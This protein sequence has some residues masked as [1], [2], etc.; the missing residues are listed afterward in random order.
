MQDTTLADYRYRFTRARRRLVRE[1]VIELVSEID[2][3]LAELPTKHERDS[4]PLADDGDWQ[5]LAG[6]V[7][8]IERLLAQDLARKGR[9][10]DLHRH[11]SF[12][13][14]VDL[15]D[16]AEWDWPS[17]RGDIMDAL[18]GELEPLPIDATDLGALV[19]ARPAG[20]VTTALHWAALDDD[21][22]ERL[23]FNLISQTAG[24]EN[25]RWLMK[26]RAPDRGR[27]LSVDRVVS[28]ALSGTRRERVIIQCKHWLSRSIPMPECA[29]AVAAVKLWEPPVVDSLIIASSG[30]FT[31]D[32]VQWI[33]RHN[34]SRERPPIEVWADSHLEFLLAS[35][36]ALVTEF[37]LR[38]N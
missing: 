12:A 35:R 1:R 19:A 13:L 8:E 3:L 15:H 26:T 17:V 5:Q 24:Y 38:K 37:G 30:R 23:M 34:E 20:P 31:A 10:S 2:G 22:F 4:T 29:A 11:L 7:K 33:E 25:A 16:I 21:E 14:G 28:D 9:W 32:A 6:H 36:A 18:Y 27:D